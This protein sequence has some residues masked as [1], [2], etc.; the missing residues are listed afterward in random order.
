MLRDQGAPSGAPPGPPPLGNFSLSLN[1]K[2]LTYKY[3]YFTVSE[4]K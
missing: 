2:N 3:I 1:D 4:K